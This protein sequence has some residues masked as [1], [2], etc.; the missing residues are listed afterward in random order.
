MDVNKKGFHLLPAKNYSY[1]FVTASHLPKSIMKRYLMLFMLI[2]FYQ[3]SIG[4]IMMHTNI[5]HTPTPEYLKT[6]NFIK[7]SRAEFEA[8]SGHKL[9]FAEKLYFKKIQR[10]LAKTEITADATISKYYDQ[11]KGKF[12]LDMVWFVLGLIIGPFA[13]LFS[14]TSK[15]SKMKR[16]SALIGTVGFIIWFGWLFLF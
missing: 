9:S 8:A 6:A 14:Y 15:Q 16:T 10:R 4:S 11:E 3:F 13:I 5:Y 7:M 12:K 2:F 1:T